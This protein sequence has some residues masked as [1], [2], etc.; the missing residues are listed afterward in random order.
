MNGRDER[1]ITFT[2]ADATAEPGQIGLGTV[3]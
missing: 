3:I 2:L 1:S